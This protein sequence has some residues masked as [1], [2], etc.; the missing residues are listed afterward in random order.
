M[1]D[2]RG[3][4]VAGCA[5]VPRRFDNDVSRGT[6]RVLTVAYRVLG[7]RNLRVK[8]LPYEVDNGNRYQRQQQ[9]QKQQGGSRRSGLTSGGGNVDLRRGLLGP[10][11]LGVSPTG[12]VNSYND[13]LDVPV[14]QVV[15]H[16]AYGGQPRLINNI[17]VLKLGRSVELSEIGGVSAACL[18]QCR[19]MFDYQFKN[20]TGTR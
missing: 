11:V 20:N 16:P 18:P 19:G 8:L 13:P 15:I 2:S 9:R 10:D 17:A 5:V 3:N 7:K 4:F 6:D 1:E 14:S 12:E